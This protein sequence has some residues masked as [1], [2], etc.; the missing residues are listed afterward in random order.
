MIRAPPAARDSG[1]PLGVEC[2]ADLRVTLIPQVACGATQGLDSPTIGIA[3][4]LTG[5]LG[6][7]PATDTGHG[8]D[9]PGL[10]E[11]GLRRPS[12]ARDRSVGLPGFAF[13][14]VRRYSSNRR[15]VGADM[16][17]NNASSASGCSVHATA[18]TCSHECGPHALRYALAA[19]V[20]SR[21]PASPHLSL[22]G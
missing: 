15:L 19:S 3:D 13:G 8:Q 18:I 11:F 2:S 17:L 10:G 12:A 20:S 14:S 7:E 22:S 6:N 5:D 21:S 16:P 4:G 9:A 1:C